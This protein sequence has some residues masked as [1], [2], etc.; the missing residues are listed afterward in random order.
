M[1]DSIS[2][3][4]QSSSN[5]CDPLLNVKLRY[6]IIILIKIENGLIVFYKAR[7]VYYSCVFGHLC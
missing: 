1:L 6:V 2:M 5:V 4:H 3:V 7:M